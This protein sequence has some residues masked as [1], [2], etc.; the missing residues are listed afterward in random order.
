MVWASCLGQPQKLK[1][2]KVFSICFL[3][4]YYDYALAP[5]MSVE[6]VFSPSEVHSIKA[7]MEKQFWIGKIIPNFK[8]RYKL[9]LLFLWLRKIFQPTHNGRVTRDEELGNL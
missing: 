6:E 1:A 3:Y 8:G 2:L 7:W 4:G 9:A 5:L